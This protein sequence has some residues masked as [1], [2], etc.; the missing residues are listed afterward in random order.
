MPVPT[1]TDDEGK[2]LCAEGVTVP[3]DE[4]GNYVQYLGIN[5]QDFMFIPTRS[6]KQDLAKDFLKYMYSEDSLAI[7]EEK[8]QAPVCFTCNDEEIEL[9]NWAKQVNSYVDNAVKANSLCTTY[10]TNPMFGLGALNFVSDTLPYA[11]LSQGGYGSI[12]KYYDSKTMKPI[13]SPEEA[14]GIA[15][16]ENVYNYVEWNYN[17]KLSHWHEY[18]QKLGIL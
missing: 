17:Y 13:A 7:I 8:I 11:K 5:T 6:V 15:I 14:E 10:S 3:T 1:M 18:K 9:N 2:A 12:H 16:T 4:N